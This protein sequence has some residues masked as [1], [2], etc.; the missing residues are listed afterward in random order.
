MVL[1]RVL[2]GLLGLAA[3]V[4]FVGYLSTGQ[5]VWRARGLAIVKWTLIAALAFFAVLAVERLFEG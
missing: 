5:V 3:V 1:F 2:L 4:C